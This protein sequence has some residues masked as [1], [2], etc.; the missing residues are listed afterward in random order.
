MK[1]LLVLIVLAPFFAFGQEDAIR[2]VLKDQVDC[3]NSGDLECYMDGY[4]KSD[5]LMFVGKKGVTYGWESTLAMYK[6]SYPSK[7]KMGKLD[8]TVKEI[9]PLSDDYWFV[10][11]QWNL[12]R[13]DDAPNGHF[14][15]FV[16][17]DRWRME[18]SS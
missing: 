10:I 7:E 16:S 18:S 12:Q 11:G 14:S 8:L 9:Y 5:Q 2:E 17:N 13:K 1:S 4:W 6:S 15:L 3:W